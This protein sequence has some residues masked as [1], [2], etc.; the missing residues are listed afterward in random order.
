MNIVFKDLKESGVVKTKLD[1]IIIPSANW[2]EM[3]RDLQKVFEAL[4]K[5]RLTLKPAKCNFATEQ[6]HF[7]GYQISKGVIKPGRKVEAIEN[8]PTP[9]EAHEVRR[10]LGLTGYFRRFIVKYAEIAEPLTCLTGKDITFSWDEKQIRA[11]EKLKV[12]LSSELVVQMY[13]ATAPVTEIHTD[14]NS[15]ALSGILLQGPSSTNLHN[16]VYMLSAKKQWTPNPVTTHLGLN[17]ML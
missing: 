13:N 5:A 2:D 14:A 16:M 9:K 8:F 3:I 17:Y 12:V 4:I 11:F 10:F 6:L 15:R 1:D 7:M